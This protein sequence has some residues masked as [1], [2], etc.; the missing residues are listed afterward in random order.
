MVR[1]SNPSPRRLRKLQEI[2]RLGISVKPENIR[3][4]HRQG[5]SSID[6]GG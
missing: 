6:Y 1:K 4:R 5:R 2:G 3:S